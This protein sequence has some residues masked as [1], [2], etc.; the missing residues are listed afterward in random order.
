LSRQTSFKGGEVPHQ[1]APRSESLAT[2]LKDSC[3]IPT[4][5]PDNNAIWGWQIR[6]SCWGCPFNHLHILNLKALAILVN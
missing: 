5:P 3:N 2:H 4:A 1:D 6:Q